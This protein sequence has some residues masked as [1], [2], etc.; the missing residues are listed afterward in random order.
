MIARF[1]GV[2]VFIATMAAAQT[3][4]PRD[5]PVYGGDAGGARFSPLTGITR[6][7]VAKLTVAWAYHT[8]EPAF[9][10]SGNR[11]SR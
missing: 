3:P 10:L 6:E 9:D 1:A 8:G 11:H 7:N 2:L 5:W 4:A